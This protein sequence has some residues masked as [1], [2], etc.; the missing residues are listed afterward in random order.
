MGGTFS[1]VTYPGIFNQNVFEYMYF[2]IELPYTRMEANKLDRRLASNV[3]DV[4]YTFDQ[5]LIRFQNT[6]NL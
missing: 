4:N 5:H 2:D 6:V 3:V 1:N